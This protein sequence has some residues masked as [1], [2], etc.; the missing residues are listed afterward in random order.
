MARETWVMMIGN[1]HAYSVTAES[2]EDARQRI[3]IY[4]A[5]KPTFAK[6]LATWRAKGRPVRSLSMSGPSLREGE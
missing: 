6:A 4:N 1:F 2:A 5:A 3:E